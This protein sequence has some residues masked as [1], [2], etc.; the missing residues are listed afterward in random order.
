LQALTSLLDHVISKDASGVD[1][2]PKR[3][4][5]VGCRIGTTPLSV[6]VHGMDKRKGDGCSDRAWGT[7]CRVALSITAGRN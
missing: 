3:R 5:K 4:E 2:I 7:L 6:A 1:D